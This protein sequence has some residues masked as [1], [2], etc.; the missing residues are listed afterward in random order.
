MPTP[1]E[2]LQKAKEAL[3]S[4]IQQK[5]NNE[6]F[7]SSV[8]PAIVE[9]LTPTL[10]E[11]GDRISAG[12]IELIKAL[13]EIR[14][15]AP[16][17]D[18]PEAIVDV[19]IPEIRVPAPQVT[20]NVP[21]IK[22][23]PIKV[24]EPKVTVNVPP[25][26][27]IPDFPKIEFPDSMQ[28]HGNV[29]LVGFD[30]KTPLAVRLVDLK[31][32]PYESASG[33]MA[34]GGRGDFFTIKDIQNSTGG[35]IIDSDGNLK[36]A[37]TFTASGG[38][39]STQIIDSSANP[40]SQANPL[41]VT[42]VSGSAATTGS[43]LVDSSG[44]QYSGSNPL[45]TTASLSVPSGQGDEATAMR[46][47]V[48]GNSDVSVSA[49]QV[50]TWNI[51]A[52]TSITNSVAATL[53][54]SS[55]VAY[56]GSNPVPT[57]GSATLSAAVGQGDAASAL[58]VVIAG[59]SDASVSA[60]Q[61]GTWNIGTVTTVTGITNSVAATLV[62]SS[63]VAYSGSNPLPTTAS[64][65]L[66]AATG[67]GDSDSALRTVQA[68]DSSSSVAAT[69]VGTWN[70]GT[71]TTVTGVTNSVAASLVDGT[72]VAYTGSN[73]VPV[74]LISGS[75][76]TTSAVYTRQTN[77]TAVAADYVPVA[78]DDLGRT[79]TRPIQVRDLI[80]TAYTT[81]SNGT[82]TTILTAA[83]ATYLDCI[84]VMCINTSTNAQQV[85]I[86]AVSGGNIVTSIYIPAQST[87][88]W[89][90]PVP[91]PQDATGNAWTADNADVTNSSIIISALF[92]KEV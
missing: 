53:V 20:V 14:I 56:S 35:S 90:P 44:V 36:I 57:S 21:E 7:V 60:V 16:D 83:A 64:V 12:N 49:T 34:S 63:G 22:I 67:Q 73:P 33:G 54:D 41:P 18:I 79:V 91:W 3:A 40:V 71:V 4:A 9:A 13:K 82:E 46:V 68:G 26:P 6:A 39:N 42:V 29:G 23:P 50:G 76:S 1:T 2:I 5:K 55:G 48:A 38:N 8:G 47:V 75:L 84:A 72:G 45:P 10:I 86:R 70:I 77:P 43:A 25:F 89:T 87:A 81:L 59:N 58:R 30:Y 78:A 52:V 61:S 24:P 11:V 88:G 17:L 19:K 51:T 80:A 62:D 69:Q 85:D 27:K 74:A 31:G 65:T 32:R 28:V 15:E 92:S 37:G 66:S